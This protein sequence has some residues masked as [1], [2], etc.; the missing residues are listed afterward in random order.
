MGIPSHLNKYW[1]IVLASNKRG[2]KIECVCRF[3]INYKFV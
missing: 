2:I 3:I 1:L